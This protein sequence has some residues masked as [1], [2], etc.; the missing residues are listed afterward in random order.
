[1]AKANKKNKRKL[2]KKRFFMF[3]IILV[4]LVIFI[5]KIFNTNIKNIYV[6]GN[7]FFTDQEIID[8]AGIKN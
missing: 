6:S 3:M 7:D 1:M 4:V 8:I 2:N 5:Y